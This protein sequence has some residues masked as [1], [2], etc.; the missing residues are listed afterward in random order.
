MRG[1]DRW[2][3]HVALVTGATSGIGRG[4]ARALAREGLRVAAVGRRRDNLETLEREIVAEEGKLLALACDLRDEREIL[5]AF[6][7]VRDTWGG[8]DVLVNGAGLGRDASLLEGQTEAWREMLEVNVLAMC[9]C[10][11]EA[12]RSMRER[13]IDGHVIHISSMSGHRVPEESGIY[14]ATK[15]AVRALTESLRRELR[16]AKSLIRVSSI[17]PGYVE[18]EF[19]SVYWNDVDRARETYS[20]YPVLQTEDVAEVVLHVIG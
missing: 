2:R 15:F 4:V 19:A 5:A 10:T 18:T 14:A 7:E 6:H 1:L 8:V 11:R 16:G 12:V 13:H 3:D 17:S 20:R 9:V